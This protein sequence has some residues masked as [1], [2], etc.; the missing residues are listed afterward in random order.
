M[1]SHDRIKSLGEVFTPPALVVE[2]LDKLPFETWSDPKKI[3]GDITGCGNGN[4]LVEVLTRKLSHGSSPDQALSTIFGI[5]IMDDNVFECR[6]RLIQIVKDRDLIRDVDHLKS[7]FAIVKQNI[8][9]GDALKYDWSRHPYD[10]E[11]GIKASSLPVVEETP[12]PRK[13]T[14]KAP[15]ANKADKLGVN[16]SQQKAPISSL[17]PQTKQ[18]S[19]SLRRKLWSSKQSA[20][21]S[22][23][24]P[25]ATGGFFLISGHE[26]KIP[27]DQFFLFS[28]KHDAQ[29]VKID[30]K[31]FADDIE[32]IN[33][34]ASAGKKSK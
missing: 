24:S 25:G 33:I 28:D 19:T 30:N 7:L 16:A 12:S 22:S 11:P 34:G 23:W 6:K 15:K 17:T 10:H 21:K 31:H 20:N 13:K 32:L 1:R 27:D 14:S 9:W 18:T 2:M 3:I 26:Y 29:I 8:V 5:D 4:F